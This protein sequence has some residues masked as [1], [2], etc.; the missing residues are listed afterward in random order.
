M[1]TILKIDENILLFIQEYIRTGILT[2]IFIPITYLGEFGL[3][4]IILTLLLLLSEKFRSV[5]IICATALIEQLLVVNVLL[6]HLINR[7]RPYEVVD[8]LTSEI[9]KVWDSSFPSGHSVASWMIAVIIFMHFPRRYG[10]FAL[11]MAVLISFSRLYLGVH[12]PTDVLAGII[13]GIIL[14]LL[15]TVMFHKLFPKMFSED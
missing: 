7:I 12:Y 2:R 11:I 5:G 6:K 9:P 13:C 14:G 8:G 4:E 1:Q 3:I 10:I 15:N